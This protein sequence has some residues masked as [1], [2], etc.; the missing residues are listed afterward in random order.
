MYEIFYKSLIQKNILIF[1]PLA[2]LPH[3]RYEY[4]NFL[5]IYIDPLS[6]YNLQRVFSNIFE[7]YWKLYFPHLKIDGISFNK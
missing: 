1:F 3:V 6:Q 2:G 5:I 4:L 7:I